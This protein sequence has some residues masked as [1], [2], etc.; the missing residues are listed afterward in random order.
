MP[1]TTFTPFDA[2]DYLETEEDIAEFIDAVREE[3]NS[4][5]SLIEHGQRHNRR[6]S[7]SDGPRL[8]RH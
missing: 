8:H 7:C 4:D 2:A 5:Q 6:C 3:A 1:E